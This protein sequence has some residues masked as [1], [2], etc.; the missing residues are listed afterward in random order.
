MWF[1]TL[2]VSVYFGVRGLVE[3]LLYP[4]YSPLQLPKQQH[5][6]LPSGGELQEGTE[7]ALQLLFLH[8]NHYYQ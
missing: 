2:V 6:S 1:D 4:W 7:R 3:S 5:G 8:R